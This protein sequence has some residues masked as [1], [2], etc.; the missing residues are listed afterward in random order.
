MKRSAFPL[1]WGRYDRH[2]HEFPAGSIDPRR[3]IAMDAVAG[4]DDAGE[5]FDIEMDERSRPRVLI[6]LH[7]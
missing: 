6:P 1:V 5:R 4:A 2:V 7:G 3:T